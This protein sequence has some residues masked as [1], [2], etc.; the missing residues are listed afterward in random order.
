MKA[1]QH[2][3]YGYSDRFENRSALPRRTQPPYSRT[4][5]DRLKHYFCLVVY[6]G[7]WIAAKA[8]SRPAIL[9]PEDA[10]VLSYEW[11]RILKATPSH[12]GNKVVIV[13]RGR[14]DEDH[15]KSVAKALLA[16]GFSRVIVSSDGRYLED[17]APLRVFG[18]QS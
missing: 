11:T 5:L 6:L 16:L 13:E 8:D 2:I 1:T 17:G 15:A 18:V 4:A 3:G 9:I 12:E 10:E 14:V 7:D